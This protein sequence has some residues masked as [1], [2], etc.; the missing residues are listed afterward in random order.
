MLNCGNVFTN[1]LCA[2][3][4]VWSRNQPCYFRS[5]TAV[6]RTYRVDCSY[7]HSAPPRLNERGLSIRRSARPAAAP[8]QKTPAG[9]SI[10]HLRR[11]ALAV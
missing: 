11:D 10:A 2:G 3:C 7:W 4:H 5:H 1:G 8:M 9:S 6:A